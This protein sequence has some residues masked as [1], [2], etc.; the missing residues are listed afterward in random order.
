MYTELSHHAD[1]IKHQNGGSCA[2][3]SLSWTASDVDNIQYN[4]NSSTNMILF[5]YE[6]KTELHDLRIYLGI[7]Q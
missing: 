4:I 3:D 7:T 2:L 1:C 6:I 5:Y